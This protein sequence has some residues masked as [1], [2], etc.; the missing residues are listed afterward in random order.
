MGSLIFRPF[1][2]MGLG[3]F[4]ASNSMGLRGILKVKNS[5]CQVPYSHKFWLVPNL[6][7]NGEAIL[8]K[9]K[10]N[11]LSKNLLSSCCLARQNTCCPHCCHTVIAIP[12]NDGAGIR[13]TFP[14]ATIVP[15]R[16]PMRQLHS[17]RIQPATINQ[18][19][20]KLN[21]SLY[22][23]SNNQIKLVYIPTNG[24]VADL[25]IFWEYM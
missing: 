5:H 16:Q 9:S 25:I 10:S 11:L 4:V 13:L 21:F 22:K 6:N 8:W 14:T 12:I 23:Y 24:N 19:T 18:S 20:S 17:L 2:N 15:W 1:T 7:P 3:E